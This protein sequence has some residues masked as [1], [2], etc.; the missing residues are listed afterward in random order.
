MRKVE[1][2]TPSSVQPIKAG[3]ITERIALVVS[4]GLSPGFP[5]LPIPPGCKLSLKRGN[6]QMVGNNIKKA[7][8]FNTAPIRACFS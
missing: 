8:T 1:I 5:S 4:F 7:N 3:Y 2:H 6:I